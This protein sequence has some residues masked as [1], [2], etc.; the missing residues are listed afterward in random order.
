MGLKVFGNDLKYVTFMGN[1][2]IQGA[3]EYF[4]VLSYLQHILSGK[5]SPVAHKQS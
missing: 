3:T 4:N 5:A 2:E 1:K